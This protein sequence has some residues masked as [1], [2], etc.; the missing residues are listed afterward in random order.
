MTS[1]G[2][3][4]GAAFGIV[5][6]VIIACIPRRFAPAWQVWMGKLHGWGRIIGGAVLL[7]AWMFVPSI[8]NDGVSIA[9]A[10]AEC[11]SGLA[12]AQ[13]FDPG[14]GRGCGDVSTLYTFLTLAAVAGLLLVLWGVWTAW[15]AILVEQGLK[16]S[17]T[18]RPAHPQ[19]PRQSPPPA[20]QPP[21]P[22]C[23][24]GSGHEPRDAFCA[25]CG[26][27]TWSPAPGPA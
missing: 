11:Q 2:W 21:E 4:L 19:P 25:T 7:L 26:R 20:P 27:P 8:S 24:C 3:G 6:A 13:A 23:T 1:L 18:A 14:I 16:F 12:I 15:G 5:A 10:H 17:T 9:Q 22:A